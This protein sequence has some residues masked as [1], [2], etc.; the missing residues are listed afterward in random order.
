MG[1]GEYNPC[2]AVYRTKCPQLNL[3][4]EDVNGVAQDT[5]VIVRDMNP[6]TPGKPYNFS[7]PLSTWSIRTITGVGLDGYYWDY[8]CENTAIASPSVSSYAGC[9]L[10]CGLTL[11]LLFLS[12]STTGGKQAYGWLPGVVPATEYPDKT[13]MDPVTKLPTG[14]VS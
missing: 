12:L 11:A 3:T 2:Q 10:L 1:T 9:L 5:Q 14:V 6:L 13:C 7:D 8:G 4:T